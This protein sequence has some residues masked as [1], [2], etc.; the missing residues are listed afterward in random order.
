MFGHN[1]G[2][3]EK[4]KKTKKTKNILNTE[5]A[6]SNTDHLHCSRN[7]SSESQS[8][9]CFN[10]SFSSGTLWCSPRILNFPAAAAAQSSMY[11]NKLKI[12]VRALKKN[13]AAFSIVYSFHSIPMQT[14][15]QFCSSGRL[16]PQT[17]DQCWYRSEGLQE[18]RA[19][20]S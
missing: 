7:F 20:R 16:H 4:S 15:G 6:L 17:N 19:G 1:L 13:N 18:A 2:R 5:E 8:E 14:E 3:L 11:K 10:A 12:V 9:H